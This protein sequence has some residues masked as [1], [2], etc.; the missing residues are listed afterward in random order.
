MFYLSISLWVIPSNSHVSMSCWFQ[1]ICEEI[2]ADA[3]PSEVEVK[4]S[5]QKNDVE[6]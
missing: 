2:Y 4:A 1:Q 5:Q 6:L 3:Q